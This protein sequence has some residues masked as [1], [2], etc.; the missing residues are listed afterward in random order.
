MAGPKTPPELL[1]PSADYQ[2]EYRRFLSGTVTVRW[3][4]ETFVVEFPAH[5]NDIRPQFNPYGNLASDA[6]GN[7]FRRMPWVRD[8]IERPNAI[9]QNEA[10]GK[11]F[12]VSEYVVEGQP[13]ALLV[14]CIS[15]VAKDN[16]VVHVLKYVGFAQDSDHA[17][18]KELAKA[19]RLQDI[20]RVCV[21]FGD[22]CN[23]RDN[24]PRWDRYFEGLQLN[25][26]V[27]LEVTYHDNAAPTGPS[28][29]WILDRNT[30]KY[31]AHT[32]D[33]QGTAN[34]RGIR[35]LSVNSPSDLAFDIDEVFVLRLT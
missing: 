13:A 3:G 1:P 5:P 10:A 9:Y 34:G 18:F 31:H 25:S 2:S 23:E 26:Q 4:A 28:E 14:C 24:R 22:L 8:T 27:S 29:I 35:C 11:L 30:T 6:L 17:S 19:T 21:C 12:L 20:C 16:R 33:F 15:R 7:P 32:F